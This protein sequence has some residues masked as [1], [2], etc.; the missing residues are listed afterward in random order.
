MHSGRP[1]YA[2][3]VNGLDRATAAGQ[4]PREKHHD[5]GPDR[6]DQDAL[7]VNARNPEPQK[8]RS[9]PSAD[10]RANDAED[11]VADDAIA[12]ALHH[13]PGQPTR[14]QT[15][16]DP[17]YDSHDIPLLEPAP[18]TPFRVAT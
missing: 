9:Q 11:D 7:D 6:G 8:G 5:D 4:S 1:R 3:N 12:A 16:D 10:N 18:A 15:D 2:S 13:H 17:G 14:N